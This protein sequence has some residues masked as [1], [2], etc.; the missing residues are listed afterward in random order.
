MDGLNSEE[1]RQLQLWL[2]QN[3]KSLPP[4][5]GECLSRMLK[6]YW[7]VL[8]KKTGSLET[9]RRLRELM[10]FLPKSEKGSQEKHFPAI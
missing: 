1:Y 2:A 9:L 5:I 4:E 6:V 3:R 10:G 8:E 7:S